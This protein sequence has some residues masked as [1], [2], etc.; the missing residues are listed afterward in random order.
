[1]AELGGRKDILIVFDEAYN[2]FV[3]ANDFVQSL[4]CFK[5]YENVLVMR[6]FSKVYG[7]AGLRVG[8][9]VGSQNHLQWINRVRNPFNV[10]TLAQEAAIAAFDDSEYLE[11]SQNVVWQG[12][13]DFYKFFEAEKI[14]F[15]KSQANFV[16]FDRLRDGQTVF[17]HA[18]KKGLLLRP[19]LGYGLPR[20]I[21]LSIG[22]LEENQKA[23][24]LLKKTFN[25]VPLL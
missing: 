8:V 3:R 6:T 18:M 9:L 11:K 5:K 10:N 24:T 17:N 4:D 2:E 16:L 7:L 13:D 12:L 25:E 22:T 19:L 20:H 23:K 15:P 14:P 1:M 21:R